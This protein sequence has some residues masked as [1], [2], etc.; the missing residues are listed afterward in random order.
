MVNMVSPW[1]DVPVRR[2]TPG[3]FFFPSGALSSTNNYENFFV[4][5]IKDSLFSFEIAR[6]TQDN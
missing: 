2:S 4:N 5:Q 1:I 3:N 6:F